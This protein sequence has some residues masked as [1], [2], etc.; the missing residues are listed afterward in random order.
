MTHLLRLNVK[1]K[2]KTIRGDLGKMGETAYL[3]KY[4]RYV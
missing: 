2:N 4:I 3:E 1:K